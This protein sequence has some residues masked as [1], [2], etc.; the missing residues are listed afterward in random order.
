MRNEGRVGT[1]LLEVG[2]SSRGR[3]PFARP[4][5]PSKTKGPTSF[6]GVIGPSG[7]P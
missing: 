4:A 7:T 3:A 5:L 1:V 2:V 6:L